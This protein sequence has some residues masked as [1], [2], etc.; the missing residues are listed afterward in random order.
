MPAQ[1]Q[2]RLIVGPDA[3]DWRSWGI[4]AGLQTVSPVPTGLLRRQARQ[5][6]WANP[7]GCFHR[8]LHI[9]RLFDVVGLEAVPT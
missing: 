9:A 3:A 4:L 6:R 2:D 8:A 5:N 1:H 7:G